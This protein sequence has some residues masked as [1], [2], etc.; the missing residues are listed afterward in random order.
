MDHLVKSFVH[1]KFEFNV[2]EF[3]WLKKKSQFFYLLVHCCYAYDFRLQLFKLVIQNILHF[4][5]DIQA[6]YASLAMAVYIVECS[7]EN[8]VH[9]WCEFNVLEFEW[10]RVQIEVVEMFN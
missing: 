10:L 9:Y 8:F 1:F 4:N 3:E 5:F 2:F 7:F 6:G